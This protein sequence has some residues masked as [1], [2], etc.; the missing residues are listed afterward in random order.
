MIYSFFV[1]SFWDTK[2]GL[3]VVAGRVC[4]K[5]ILFLTASSMLKVLVFVL[6]SWQHFSFGRISFGFSNPDLKSNC[7]FV[8]VFL[9][10]Y[11][12]D[13]IHSSF[14][15]HFSFFNQTTQSNEID[16]DYSRKIVDSSDGCIE[17][18]KGWV[19]CSNT[20]W[21]YSL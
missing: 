9:S 17:V 5:C 7:F 19:W 6:F 8:F 16:W 12:S 11:H 14:N 2:N 20:L 18:A 3:A 4:N 10:H 1:Y 21:F 13:R 15:A